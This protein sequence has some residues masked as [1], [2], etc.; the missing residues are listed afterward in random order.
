G[1][2]ALD[3]TTTQPTQSAHHRPARHRSRRRAMKRSTDR[4]LTT[5]VGSLT[6]PPEVIS[7]LDQRATGKLFEGEEATTLRRSIVDVFK[8][9]RDAGIDI[10]NDGEFSKSG[11]ANY[12]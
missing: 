6:R 2:C 1:L 4:I 3:R 12:I 11:F 7:M 5:H 8:Q 9:Q 10:P